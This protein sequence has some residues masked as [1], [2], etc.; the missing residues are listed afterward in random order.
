MA[1]RTLLPCRH[2][3]LCACRQAKYQGNGK[4][5][6]E[7]LRHVGFMYVQFALERLRFKCGLLLENILEDVDVVISNY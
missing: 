4:K 5:K 1:I 3:A 7:G 6:S 2:E